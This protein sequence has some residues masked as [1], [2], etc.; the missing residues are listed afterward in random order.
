MPNLFERTPGLDPIVILAIVAPLGLLYLASFVDLYRRPDLSVALKAIWA[1]FIFF[2][3]FIGVAIYFVARPVR[4]PEGKR[5]GKAVPRTREIV[6]QI[7]DAHAAHAR[8]ELDDG[9]YLSR[10]RQFLGLRT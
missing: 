3:A 7:E 4:P 9:D 2:T 6:T 10:K 1:T 8:G 5:Y